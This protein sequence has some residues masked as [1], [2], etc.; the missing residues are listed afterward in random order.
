MKTV[1]VLVKVYVSFGIYENIS[2]SETN[3]EVSKSS[4]VA[5]APLAH[6]KSV[7]VKRNPSTET[8]DTIPAVE[9]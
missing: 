4:K 3:V 6:H 2:V 1:D 5:S 7:V 9:S 8:K